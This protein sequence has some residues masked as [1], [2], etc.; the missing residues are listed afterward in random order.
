MFTSQS[1][2]QHNEQAGTMAK[3]ASQDP[4]ATAPSQPAGQPHAVS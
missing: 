2:R 3:P 4:G 1:D